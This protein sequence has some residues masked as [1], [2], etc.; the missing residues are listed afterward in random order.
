ML[1]PFSNR[2]SGKWKAWV[3][4]EFGGEHGHVIKWFE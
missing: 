4:D 3:A 1:L 2:K